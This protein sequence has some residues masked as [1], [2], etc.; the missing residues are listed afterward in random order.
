MTAEEAMRYLENIYDDEPTYDLETEVAHEAIKE[1]LMLAYKAL[2]NVEWGN[3][4][5]CVFCHY[6]NP[7]YHY[8]DCPRQLA[9][10]S[11]GEHESP[12]D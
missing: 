5:F 8:H 2:K 1:A 11:I 10:A 4:G 3:T 12:E 9:L 7:R 6:G